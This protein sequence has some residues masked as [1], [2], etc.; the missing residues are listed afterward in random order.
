M[1]TLTIRLTATL[2]FLITLFNLA[3]AQP[4][5]RSLAFSTLF[6]DVTDGEVRLVKKI[7]QHIQF[8]LNDNIVH[9]NLLEQLSKFRFIHS[10]DKS[11][12][13]LIEYSFG[14]KNEKTIISIKVFDRHFNLSYEHKLEFFYEEKFPLI[15]LDKFGSLVIFFP[16]TSELR[17]L[18]K[19]FS[20]SIFLVKDLEGNLERRGF[21][22]LNGG[23]SLKD[24]IATG[25]TITAALTNLESGSK[26]YL[27][28]SELSLKDQTRL[29]HRYKYGGQVAVDFEHIHSM[30]R[31]ENNSIL[32]SAYNFENELEPMLFLLENDKLSNLSET[33]IEGIVGGTKDLLFSSSSIYAFNENQI[34][35]KHSIANGNIISGYYYDN[36]LHL[37]I[38]TGTVAHYEIHSSDYEL[39]Q[40]INLDPNAGIIGFYFSETEQKLYLKTESNFISV[41]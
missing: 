28:N 15:E 40:T 2:I 7:D 9:E 1:M 21:L 38:R 16:Y 31:L 32:I 12:C 34:V 18:N 3:Q 11:F 41:N 30:H 14:G 22:L 39:L 19:S 37:L 4:N 8:I 27:L 33:L 26:V 17:I 23:L 13:A 20:K 10:N 5:L 6:E 35:K 25:G 29:P 24:A 36:K